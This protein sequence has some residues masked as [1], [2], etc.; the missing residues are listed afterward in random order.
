MKVLCMIGLASGIGCGGGCGGGRGTRRDPPAL[1]T[2]GPA[3]DMGTPH[4]DPIVVKSP[5]KT[6]KFLSAGA[7]LAIGAISKHIS[8]GLR[9]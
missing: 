8:N 4:I 3:I 2:L 7:N 5:S 6:A 1:P 9:I